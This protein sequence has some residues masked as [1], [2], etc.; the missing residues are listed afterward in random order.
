MNYLTEYYKNLCEKYEYQIQNLQKHLLEVANPYIN[1]HYFDSP[2]TAPPTSSDKPYSDG[3]RDEI[4]ELLEILKYPGW[5]WGPNTWPKPDY[6][7][8]DG[9]NPDPSKYFPKGL[10]EGNPPKR[11]DFPPG[12][13]G[14]ELYKQVL[15]LYNEAMKLLNTHR[16]RQNL[17]NRVQKIRLRGDKEAWDRYYEKLWMI[18]QD[19]KRGRTPP[20]APKE[21]KDPKPPGYKIPEKYRTTEHGT[22]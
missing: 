3:T 20:K 7:P 22:A 4:D 5:G 18:E 12:P 6:T 2:D 10:S 19:K 13:M 17:H 11:E 16:S 9:T 15:K 21:P 14:D 1:V 8:G